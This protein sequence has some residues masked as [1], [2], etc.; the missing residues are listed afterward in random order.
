M[1][2]SLA[3]AAR[4]RARRDRRGLLRDDGCPSPFFSGRSALPSAKS[5]GQLLKRCLK[6]RL[7]DL[8]LAKARLERDPADAF[9]FPGL[10]DLELFLQLGD[11]VAKFRGWLLHV[12]LSPWVR[13]LVFR[14]Q[15]FGPECGTHYCESYNRQGRCF[16][17]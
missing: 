12:R 9:R 16:R 13:K 2:S 7:V 14:T 4:A 11:F 10:G 17:E 3:S 5:L 15:F 6:L 1:R 8:D